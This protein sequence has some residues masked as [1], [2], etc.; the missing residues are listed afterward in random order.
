MSNP[1]DEAKAARR[2]LNQERNTSKAK[3]KRWNDRLD[4]VR[5]VVQDTLFGGV[6]LYTKTTRPGYMPSAEYRKRKKNKRR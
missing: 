6:P 1:R 3:I 5:D 4:T 2:A